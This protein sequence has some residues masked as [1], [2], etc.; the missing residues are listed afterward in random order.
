LAEGPILIV[1]DTSVWASYFNGDDNSKVQ[2]LDE[3]LEMENQDIAILP[4]VI[5]EVLQGFRSEAGFKKASRLFTE[6]TTIQPSVETH[7]N[8]AKLYRRLRRQG[9]TIRGTVDCII[10]QTCIE[11]K[12][13][14]LSLDRDFI[15]IAK[16]SRLI[17]V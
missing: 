2:Y 17:L 11:M 12:S 13:K 15:N 4:I 1:V 7:I 3:I 10:A 8:A 16:H 5:A 9:V 14:L 6:L